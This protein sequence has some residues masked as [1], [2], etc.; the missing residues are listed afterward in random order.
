MSLPVSLKIQ[1]N[2]SSI[3]NVQLS[4]FRFGFIFIEVF[5]NKNVS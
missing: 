4:A 5:K 3:I 1:S 2:K